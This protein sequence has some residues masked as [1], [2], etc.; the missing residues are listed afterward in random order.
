MKKFEYLLLTTDNGIFKG[1]DYQKLNNQLTQ[2]GFQGWE[3]VSTVAVSNTGGQT[4]YLLTT[5]KRE[6]LG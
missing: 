2:L 5:L 1:I 4:A 3:V 6:V